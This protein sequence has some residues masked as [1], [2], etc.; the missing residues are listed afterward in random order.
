MKKVVKFGGSSL[1]DARQFQKVKNIIQSD[2]S[3]NIVVVSAAGKRFKDDN[4]V[5]DL[6]YLCHAHMKYGVSDDGIMKIIKERYISIRDELNLTLDL[7]EEF[8]VI[9]K[10]RSLEN[11]DYLVSRGEYLCA[12]L[13]SEYLG[14][15]FVDAKDFIV[16]DFNGKLN[17]EKTKEAFK[18]LNV[19]HPKMVV[20][21]FY[22]AYVNQ[23]I[24]I[25]SRGG[26]DITGSLLADLIDADVYENWSDVS[27]ILMADPKII[28]DPKRIESIT[29][30]ELR[31]LSYMGANV[32]HE[33][34]I[35]P[36]REKNIPINILN[37]NDPTNPG[38]MILNDCSEWDKKQPAHFITGIAGKKDFTT[39]TIYKSGISAEVGVALKAF[40]VLKKYGISVE[41]MPCGI[42]SFSLIIST[43]ALTNCQYELL[44]DLKS[45]LEPESIRVSDHLS[46][47][48]VVGRGMVANPGISGQ[49]FGE[50]GINNINI[51]TIS[52][53]ADELN[54]IVGVHN[55]DF[56]KTIQVIY[57][58]FL[59]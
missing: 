30:S 56:E 48:A 39:I 27:G 8:N 36:V 25:M 57:E 59:R 33:E 52:Q 3:R 46:L 51:Q 7:E 26:S 58:K 38:T 1:A 10:Q 11:L 45:A 14:Y 23:K 9:Q 54:I 20:P 31:E 22:G 17:R 4:K 2:P 53:G 43:Q 35:F 6:L 40:E 44:S 19:L 15:D 29:Y 34:A 13:M 18:K 50:L 16:F 24:K 47:I 21:G 41:N 12:R 55:D 42:D 32:L 28:R 5:T 49:I 37:T